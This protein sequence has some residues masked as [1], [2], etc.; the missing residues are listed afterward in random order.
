[1]TCDSILQKIRIYGKVHFH[2]HRVGEQL[3]AP[4]FFNGLLGIIENRVII[5]SQIGNEIVKMSPW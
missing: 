4:T 3:S 5:I 2:L 1:M